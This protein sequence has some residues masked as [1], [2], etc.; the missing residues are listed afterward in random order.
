[1]ADLGYSSL[2]EVY[3]TRE[4]GVQVV[5]NELSLSI[6]KEMRVRTI[7]LSE[8]A[9]L[10]SVSK[11]TIQSNL[12]KLAGTGIVTSADS[13]DDGRSVVYHLDAL[14]LFTSDAPKEW[15][16]YARK[17]SID[18]IL[19][20]N[21]CSAKEDLSLYGVSLIESGLN[22][23]PGLFNVG[24]AM[25]R[26]FQDMDWWTELLGSSNTQCP[27]KG[28]DI[29]VDLKTNLV[30]TFHSD[31]E[32]ISDL[33]LVIVPMLGAIRSHSRDIVGFNLCHETNLSVGDEGHTVKLKIEPFQGQDFELRPFNWEVLN[34]VKMD[35]PFSIYSIDGKAMLF[36]NPTMMAILDALYCID[37]SLN[38]LESRLELPKATL[39]VSLTKLLE[40]GAVRLD[41]DSGSPKKYVLV[42][43]PLL[44][45]SHPFSS[46]YSKLQKLLEDFHDGKVDYYSAVISFAMETL[47]C[48]GIHFDR[49]F[50]RSGSYVASSVLQKYPGIDAEDFL[51][52]SC[53]MVSP[54]DRAE[55]SK[56]LPP[57][58]RLFDSPNSLWGP[59]SKNFLIGF[60]REGLRTILG[61]ECPFYIDSEVEHT[62]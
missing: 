27:I 26:S 18:R 49:M 43:D 29:S 54:P 51:A 34:E 6:L 20:N 50:V 47:R 19:R 42:A 15:Q 31:E 24:A 56:Y 55:V 13:L 39:F 8:M 2:Y 11:S 5:T 40:L 22:I 60:L 52:L 57:H 37:L 25:V 33:P 9:A 59:L 35:Y 21:A 14:L 7:T 3:L 44:F 46:G 48:M 30:L 53:R 41:E 28:I 12:R 45:V 4:H 58:I 36:S 10:F 32:I 17:A 61:F 62:N 38:D 23:I 16:L 1:M